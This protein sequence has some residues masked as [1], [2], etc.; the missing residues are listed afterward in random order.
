MHFSLVIT[1][2]TA[3]Q[4]FTHT[5]LVSFP[6]YSLADAGGVHLEEGVVHEEVEGLL[7]PGTPGVLIPT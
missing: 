3:V 5:Q 7:L 4:V 1:C 2:I 6:S